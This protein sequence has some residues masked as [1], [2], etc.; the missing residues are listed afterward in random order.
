V[1][2][3]QDAATASSMTDVHQASEKMGNALGKFTVD[4][5]IAMGSGALA[6]G[7]TGAVLN[8]TLSGRQFEAWKD[9]QFN[10]EQT[11]LGRFFKWSE[12]TADKMSGAV[13]EKLLG[14]EQ[15]GLPDM[16]IE[17]KLELIAEANKHAAV[18]IREKAG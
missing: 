2:T 17:R 13:A 6:E 1:E 7:A 9:V 8:R 10:S 12:R 15:P 14:R 16:P 3:Y 18:E 5:A 4:S 11:A